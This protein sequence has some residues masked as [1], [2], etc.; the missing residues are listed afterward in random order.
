[1]TAAENTEEPR[2][3]WNRSF[4]LVFVASIFLHF[5]M[6][7]SQG[8]LAPYT[9]ELGG[10]ATEVGMVTS[11]FAVTALL[12]KAISAP[13]LDSFDRKKVFSIAL[14]GT[15]VAFVGYTLST[16]VLMVGT[17]S[18]VRGASQAFT[19]T[20]ALVIATDYLPKD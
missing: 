15:A 9:A 14:L 4:L 13:V 10:S 5:G 3:I 11:A 7:M 6:Q 16:S 18:L 2:T 17:F 8:I 1:M 20:A 19:S 12:L